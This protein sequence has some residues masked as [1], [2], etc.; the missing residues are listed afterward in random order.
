EGQKRRGFKLYAGR[1]YL[2]HVFQLM[3]TYKSPPPPGFKIE[4]QSIEQHILPLRSSEIVD[5]MY[6][7]LEFLFYVLPQQMRR[8]NSFLAVENSQR[9]QDPKNL[10]PIAVELKQLIDSH[11]EK[12]STTLKK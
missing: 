2:M 10:E 9:I 8:V 11:K 5:G 7:R 4:I 6:D 3:S 1:T 12:D